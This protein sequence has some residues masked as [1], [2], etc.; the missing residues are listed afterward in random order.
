MF[1][2]ISEIIMKYDEIESL[3][4]VLLFYAP[5]DTLRLTLLN[6]GT[7]VSFMVRIHA[8]SER[9]DTSIIDHLCCAARW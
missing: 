5:S 3:V 6:L 9:V 4:H 1:Q 8:I 7:K 2:R